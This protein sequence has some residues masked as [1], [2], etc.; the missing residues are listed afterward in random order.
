MY[1]LRNYEVYEKPIK[2]GMGQV[3]HLYHRILKRHIAYKQPLPDILKTDKQKELFYKECERW[4]S[5][6]IHPHIVQCYFFNEVENIPG[7]FMEW[8][9]QGSLLAYI[10]SGKLYEGQD[11]EVLLR[12][13]DIAI[14]MAKGLAYSHKKGILHLDVKPA[15]VLID[16]HGCAKI[17]DFGISSLLHQKDAN[18]GYTLLYG[19]PEQIFKKEV[20][21]RTDIYCWAVSLL[22]M[23]VKEAIWLDGNV[24]GFAYETYLEDAL[25]KIPDALKKLLGSCLV[26]ENNQRIENFERVIK[27]LIEIYNAVSPT[28]YNEDG[29]ERYTGISLDAYNNMAVSYYHLGYKDKAAVMWLRASW[30]N[31]YYF[32]AYFNYH[33]YQY[34]HSGNMNS[35]FESMFQSVPMKHTYQSFDPFQWQQIKSKWYRSI[36]VNTTL[37]SQLNLK[38]LFQRDDIEKDCAFLSYIYNNLLLYISKNGKL[39][40]IDPK[41]KTYKKYTM[42]LQGV[43]YTAVSRDGQYVAIAHQVKGLT[44]E[45][46]PK[47]YEMIVIDLKE[48]KYHLEGRITA[49]VYPLIHLSFTEQYDEYPRIVANFGW[50]I[51][52]WKLSKYLLKLQNTPSDHTYQYII[53]QQK[54]P[55]RYLV[56]GF[57][58]CLVAFFDRKCSVYD[59]LGA[60]E[61]NTKLSQYIS[62]YKIKT[63]QSITGKNH[64]LV[65][66]LD[67][68]YFVYDYDHHCLICQDSDISDSINSYRQL[69]MNPEGNLLMKLQDGMV[70]SYDFSDYAKGADPLWEIRPFQKTSVLIADCK[71]AV[72]SIRWIDANIVKIKNKK[73]ILDDAL[74]RQILIKAAEVS[75][76][77]KNSFRDYHEYLQMTAH[78]TQ[79][80]QPESI[81]A[82]QS[83]TDRE[84]AVVKPTEDGYFIAENMPKIVLRP[85]LGKSMLCLNDTVLTTIPVL[86]H[87][88]V[89]ISKDFCYLVC[90]N[91]YHQDYK[92]QL[93]SLEWQFK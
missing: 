62:E 70:R 90:K 37:I 14:Q 52:D 25:V 91:H 6:G 51:Y 81:T 39:F 2:G 44:K 67:N 7:V 4:I 11:Q 74:Y 57:G 49:G 68:G 61:L 82:L 56:E 88:V 16:E 30:H 28:V 54:P 85:G 78:L 79:I 34:K 69:S 23:L 71:N 32:P 80:I 33:L 83:F 21:E 55:L 50:K 13:L 72:D 22:H 24:A 5:L 75:Q 84:M 48:M 36:Q 29:D 87:H 47:E 64:L 92:Y 31:F 42:H 8:M 45:Y 38:Q 76:Y 89:G 41:L 46:E 3:Y 19:A 59:A 12:I 10:E 77:Y 93:F 53:D 73:V 60:E 86:Y 18:T 65:D 66:T 9:D 35:R 15:N 40:I 43:S 27:E 1:Q 58:Y 26:R 20:N 63:I 17:T